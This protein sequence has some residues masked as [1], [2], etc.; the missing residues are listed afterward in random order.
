MVTIWSI[1]PDDNSVSGL[2]RVKVRGRVGVGVVLPRQSS[3]RR[4]ASAC[5]KLVLVQWASVEILSG[6]VDWSST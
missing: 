6:V 2:L 5:Q 4:A 1:G 3:A